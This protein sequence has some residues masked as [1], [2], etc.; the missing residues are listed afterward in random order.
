[1]YEVMQCMSCDTA[2][3]GRIWGMHAFMP[4]LEG[5]TACTKAT[6]MV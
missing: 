6:A 4:C 2:G 1:M 5:L 3:L